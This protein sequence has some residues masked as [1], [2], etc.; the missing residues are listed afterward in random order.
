[1]KNRL[2]SLGQGLLAVTVIAGFA[3]QGEDF[4]PSDDEIQLGVALEE[5]GV[6]VVDCTQALVDTDFVALTKVLTLAVPNGDDAVI[7]VVGGKLKVNGWQCKTTTGT[8]L[9]STNV[10]KINIDVAGTSKIVFDL[11]PGTFGNIFGNTGGITVTDGGAAGGVSIGVRGTAAANPFKMAQEGNAAAGPYYLELSGNAQADVKIVGNPDA[12]S[13]ALGD[14]PDTFSAQ[15]Q[16]LTVSH[17]SGTAPTTSVHA[18]EP[19]SVFGGLGAD[20][21]KGGLGDDTI[22]GGPGN[23]IFQMSATNV[24]D[25]ADTYIGGDGTDL[26]DYSTRDAA[27]NVSIAPTYARGWVEGV[28][29]FDFTVDASETLIFNDGSGPTTIT[30]PGA[31]TVGQTAI[32]AHLNSASGFNSLAVAS[33]NDRGEL[34]VVKA[35]PA[36]QMNITG[37][38]AGLFVGTPTNNGVSQLAIDPDDGMTAEADDVRADVEN[39]N[40]SSVADVISG[41]LKSNVINGNGGNDDISGGIAGSDCAQDVDALNG[42]DGD[43]MFRLGSL[44]NCSDV[45]DGNAG[46]DTANYELRS[47]VMTIDLDSAADD[48]DNAVTENDN[49]KTTVEVVMGGENNDIITGGAADEE[50]HGGIGN[51]TLTGGA[52]ADTLVGG[53]G[54]DILLG[55]VGNDTI[56]EKAIDDTPYIKVFTTFGG[57]DVIN[58]GTDFDVCDYGRAAATAMAF[59]LCTSATVNAAGCATSN[60]DGPAGELDDLTNCDHLIG[61]GGIDT[62]TGSDGDDTVEG[63]AGADV[64]NGGA[65]NDTLFGDAD[66]DTLN[67]GDGEDSLDG[68]GGTNTIDGGEDVDICLEGTLTACEL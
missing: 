47:A 63:G 54:N 7:S 65:G 22:D 6:E 39:V 58:G 27:V 21:I 49:I 48:G 30:F 45:V 34:V 4:T 67:G 41:S 9:T 56:S 44:A 33:V 64:I 3:C 15:D 37:G 55:G 62:V 57:A 23:D 11:L 17:L 14:G 59:T 60:D 36:G 28:N 24:D 35:A 20:I 1:M 13:F 10:N 8:E 26:V 12:V 19:I 52:G 31:P 61:G 68:G 32:L 29:I 5:L 25:G 40:G 51:D 42:G 50:L 18:G 38:T 16:L 46:R 66:N 2:T 43:D 53:T